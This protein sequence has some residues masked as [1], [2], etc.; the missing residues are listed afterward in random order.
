MRKR[1]ILRS[2]DTAM[3][4]S[5]SVSELYAVFKNV[6][7]SKPKA[8]D[9]SLL[10]EIAFALDERSDSDIAP[11]KEY[12][13]QKTIQRIMDMRCHFAF[14]LSRKK[15]AILV[16]ALIILL[17]SV[18]LALVNWNAIIESVFHLESQEDH[19]AQWS[20][21][22]KEE[23]VN[24][25]KRIEYDMTGLPDTS[26]L[27]EDEKDIV[28]TNWL[29]RQFQGSKTGELHDALMI[30][31]NGF[32][33]DWSMEDQAWYSNM[34][35]NDGRITEGDFVY[36]V[37]EKGQEAID[38][39]KELADEQLHEAFNQTEIDSN[40][41][42][43]YF[44]YGYFYPDTERLYWRISYKSY[45]TAPRMVV[46]VEDTTPKQYFAKIL[47]ISPA[48][49]PSVHSEEGELAT[50][51]K[52]VALE[53]EHGPLITWPYEQQASFVPEIYGVPEKGDITSQE[54]YAIARKAYCEATGSTKEESE[55][56]YCYSYFLIDEEKP[57]YA[58]SFF[59]DETAS[60][61]YDFCIEIYGDGEIK[62]VFYN[63][64]G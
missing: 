23:I 7:F 6:I 4:D 42:T 51:H 25:L 45:Q 40:W 56:L 59:Y 13:W 17:A 35:L 57:Y 9:V 64:N 49:M 26:D 21:S 28:L 47:Y 52:E 5:Y 2:L 1:I 11:H 61:L 55:K 33:D 34:L 30:R 54:A 8:I 50:D 19:V 53:V 58:I 43:P 16:I 18:A 10:R 32:F 3:N 46:L 63:G 31:L 41:L 24:E 62:A 36:V 20:L 37:P 38:R 48:T 27:M 29:N 15:F 14:G 44:S 60:M 12:V 39:V 22:Q